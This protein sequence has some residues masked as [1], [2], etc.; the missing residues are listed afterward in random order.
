MLKNRVAPSARKVTP[1]AQPLEKWRLAVQ[2]WRPATP[3]QWPGAWRMPER[4]QATL[5][6]KHEILIP[7]AHR[8]AGTPE[9]SQVMHQNSEKQQKTSTVQAV[10]IQTKPYIHQSIHSQCMQS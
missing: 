10:Y 5:G 2:K 4:R 6:E 3:R 1:G 7:V 9:C 8:L